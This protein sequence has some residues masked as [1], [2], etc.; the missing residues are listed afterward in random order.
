MG[1]ERKGELQLRL[2]LPSS[3]AHVPLKINSVCVLFFSG[4]FLVVSPGVHSSHCYV[5]LVATVGD[6]KEHNGSFPSTDSLRD[7]VQVASLLSASIGHSVKW[8]W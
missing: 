2:S 6:Q 5:F 1:G 4:L 7:L 8:G 3:D